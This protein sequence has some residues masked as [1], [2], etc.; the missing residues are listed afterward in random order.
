MSEKFEERYVVFSAV[1]IMVILS[2]GVIP[3]L[4][5]AAMLIATFVGAILAIFGVMFDV[6][7]RIDKKCRE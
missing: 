1:L 2:V 3:G 6:V 7:I 5:Y 4:T